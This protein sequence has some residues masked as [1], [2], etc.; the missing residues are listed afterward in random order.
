M[1]SHV[2]SFLA[3]RATKPCCLNAGNA[4]ASRL[5]MGLTLTI[6]Q[7]SR[8]TAQVH[9]AA[10]RFFS[11]PSSMGAE[12][13]PLFRIG[14]RRF[15]P[16]S[17][18]RTFTTSTESSSRR[19]FSLSR[20]MLGRRFFSAEAQ[21]QAP[22]PAARGGRNMIPIVFSLLCGGSAAVVYFIPD[23]TANSISSF[24]ED[25]NDNSRIFL[26]ALAERIVPQR[27]APW[28]LDFATMNYPEYLP[29]LVMDLDKVLIKMEYDRHHGWQVKKRPGAD[30]F[31]NELQFYYELVIFSDEVYPVA[32]D[33]VTKWGLRIPSVL[34]RE[35][36]IRKK[37]HYVKDIS[38]LGRKMEKLVML[39]H[40]P[41]AFSM[42]PENG[43][44][45]KPYDGDI[46]DRE[47]SDLLDFLKALATSNKDTRDFIS[48]FGGGDED[49]G[50]RYRMWKEEKEKNAEKKRG[51]GRSMFGGGGNG[52]SALGGRGFGMGARL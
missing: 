19:A 49:I 45:I 43:I 6:R 46:E 9:P 5:G 39:D 10:P 37:S 29:T 41:E 30:E 48:E 2:A 33:V 47:L 3:H 15:L 52:S 13:T 24:L 23:D 38:K 44:L 32:Q 20:T 12:K 50:R 42:Q 26:E 16:S 27:P 21:A 28:L 14:G 22:L 8:H 1:T 35:F 11:S 51:I 17:S 7:A 36:C 40:D 25:T 34:H 31:L 18:F 4:Q